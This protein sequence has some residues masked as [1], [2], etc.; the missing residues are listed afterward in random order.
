[1]DYRQSD[2][3][4]IGKYFSSSKELEACNV[5]FFRTVFS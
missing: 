4:Q 2:Y 1:M 3:K 5:M